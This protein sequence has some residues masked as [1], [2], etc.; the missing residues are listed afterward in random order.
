MANKKHVM[1]ELANLGTCVMYKN[2][3]TTI[4]QNSIELTGLPEYIDEAQVNLWLVTRGMVAFFKD[5]I[6]DAYA[7]LPF[8]ITGKV[9]MYNNPTTIEVFAPNGYHKRLAR[10]EYVIIYDNTMKKTIYPTI[11]EFAERMALNRRIEDINIFNQK[12]PKIYQCTNEQKLTLQTMLE[13]LDT[14]N[15][16]ILASDNLDFDQI[17]TDFNPAPFVADKI[18]ENAA[19]VFGEFLQFIGITSVSL[20]KKERLITSEITFSQG[21]ALVSRMGRI[22]ARQSAVDKINAKYDLNIGVQFYDDDPAIKEVIDNVSNMDESSGDGRTAG[23]TV[24]DENDS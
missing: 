4:A 2:Y 23:T 16:T 14:F 13:S 3:L 19:H 11:L 1:R 17:T 18:S 9:D 21:G 7:I 20:E 15:T 10:G 8:N 24:R 12:T 5:E 6:A 22:N